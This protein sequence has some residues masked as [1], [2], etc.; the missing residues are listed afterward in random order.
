MDWA[1]LLAGVICIDE[2]AREFCEES[3]RRTESAR[4]KEA[5]DSSRGGG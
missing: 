3:W 2:M 5:S 4:G 1:N